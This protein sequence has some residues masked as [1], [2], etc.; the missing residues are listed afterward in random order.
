MKPTCW[1]FLPLS[2]ELNKDFQWISGGDLN[3]LTEAHGKK[4]STKGKVSSILPYFIK[5]PLDDENWMSQGFFNQNLSFLK[6]T[7]SITGQLVWTSLKEINQQILLFD[8]NLRGLRTLTFKT[9]E[10]NVEKTIPLDQ[11]SSSHKKIAES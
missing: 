8:L 9:S 6:E 3:S 5:N 2:R 11:K 1:N 4:G 7:C 10:R